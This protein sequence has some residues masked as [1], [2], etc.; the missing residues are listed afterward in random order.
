[1]GILDQQD[2]GMDPRT[3]GI[4]Q[5][6]FALMKASGASRM[7]V[8]M[9]EALGQA[10]AAGTSAYAQAQ[11][12]ELAKKMKR[13]QIAQAEQE[14]AQRQQMGSVDMNNP[15]SLRRYG[16]L[17][18]K[19]EYITHAERIEK[20]QEKAKEVAGMRSQTE[21]IPPDPQEVALAADQGTPPPSPAVA[22][23]GGIF[24]ELQKAPFPD[25]ATEA[26][27]RQAEV[28]RGT[29]RDPE[30]IRAERDRLYGMVEKRLQ[31]Q[32]AGSGMHVVKDP[33]S[34]TGWSYLNTS[35]K[36]LKDAPPPASAAAQSVNDVVPAAHKDWHGTDYLET[37]PTGMAASVKAMAEGK[38]D[39]KGASMRYGNQEAQRQRVL[40]YDPT[41]TQQRYK[42]RQAFEDPNGKTGQNI[43]AMNT[44]ISHMGT[45]SELT[46]ALKNGK[47]QTV[48]AIVN[49]IRTE[50][51]NPA[52]N[53]AQ[54]AIQAM[55]NELMRVFR[56]VGA[57]EQET[58]AWESRFNAA[59]GDPAYLRSALKVG[60]ELLQGRIDAVDD[61]WKRSM[62]T[63]EGYPN[64]LSAKSKTA[65]ERIN[66]T[67]IATT[68]Q[69]GAT[70]SRIR[71]F[72]PATGRIE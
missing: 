19:P 39:L 15:E 24:G 36:K 69:P 2:E 21:V 22:K 48:N 55:G 41:F 26:A 52:I 12:A 31:L 8:G 18:K 6:A 56:Q 28:D 29:T 46:D 20:E 58:K 71:K 33:S 35:G 45:V 43:T 51:N 59:K 17:T 62:G 11:E 50:F 5:A 63:E 61:Q 23:K 54:L 53:D 1:M 13:M 42:N 25:V 14:L 32:D 7:P 72:N 57:S 10:G 44:V 70:P 67:G 16:I 40:Q 4:L 3:Q 38:M 65:L 66:G 30:K 60:A 64:L 9:G 68:A 49:R 47:Q 34:S 27:A 37:L